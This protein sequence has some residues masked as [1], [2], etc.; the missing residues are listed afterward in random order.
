MLGS[1]RCVVFGLSLLSAVAL[2]AGAAQS[3]DWPTKPIRVL[4]AGAPGGSSDIYVRLIEPHVRE[5]L[6]QPMYLDNRP[7]AGGML[8]AGIAAGSPPDGYN[9]FVSNSATNAIGVTL[10]K[11]PT[12]N[13][14]KELPAVALMA[15]MTNAVV[16]RSDRGI[17]SFQELVAYIKSNPDKAFYGSAGSGTSSHLSGVLFGQKTG[18]EPTHVPY[19]GTAANMAGVLAG[20]VLFA[21]DNLPLYVPHV[22]SGAVKLLAVTQGT[23]SALAPDVPSVVELGIRE[24]EGYSWFGLSTSTGTPPEIIKKLAGAVVAAVNSPEVSARIREIGAEP[25]PMGPEEYDAF[26]KSEIAKWAPVIKA[27]G[28]VVD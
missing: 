10:Y 3:Q 17:N 27:S 21:I 14:D 12:F 1:S 4:S 24:L 22:K 25:A 8:A 18:T 11:K 19:K 15:R 26:I 13:P 28:A 2:L 16:V 23:R 7:G 5:K 9:L 20:E 6:G